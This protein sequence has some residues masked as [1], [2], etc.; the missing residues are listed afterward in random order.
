MPDMYDKETRSRV[1]SCIRS[2]DTKAEIA[3]RKALWRS[4]VRGYRVHCKMPGKPDV[5]FTRKKVIVFIDGDFWHGYLWKALGKIPPEGYWQKKIAGNMQRDD[6]QNEQYRNDG[7]TV[8]R[9][10]EH[11]ILS[12]VEYCVQ[13]VKEQLNMTA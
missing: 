9:F 5:V 1:M 11:E 7:W 3:F 8:I 4:G 13:K 2:K 6:R 10:W 12:D